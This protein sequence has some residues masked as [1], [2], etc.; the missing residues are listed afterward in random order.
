MQPASAA[1]LVF[2]T[3]PAGV[4]AGSPFTTQPVV[5]AKDSYGN[6]A[7]GYAKTVSLS[8]KSGTGPTGATLSGCTS[9][10]SAGVTTFSGCQVSLGGAPAY[11]LNASG[12][13]PDRDQRLV[14]RRQPDHRH[15]RRP[16]APTR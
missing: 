9:S 4:T 16:P 13:H 8:I 14:H 2:T 6:V 1:S 15:A 10:L 3:Q 11:Q 12:R 7:T 5:T